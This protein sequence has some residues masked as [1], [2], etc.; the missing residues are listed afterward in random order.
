MYVF[1]RL[2]VCLIVMSSS[3]LLLNAMDATTMNLTFYAD[4]SQS[5]TTF[6]L[7]KAAGVGDV[8]RM[9]SLLQTEEY[10]VNCENEHKERPLHCAAAAGHQKAVEFLI[11]H[12]ASPLVQDDFKYTPVHKASENGRTGIVQHILSQYKFL[13]NISSTDGT[14]PLML[15]ARNGHSETVRVL[16]QF[17]AFVNAGNEWNNTALTMA[18]TKGD[19]TTV[20]ILLD[21]GASV[22]IK[23]RDGGQTPLEKAEMKVKA[24]AGHPLGPDFIQI[25]SMLQAAEAKR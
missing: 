22:F 24:Y 17:E 9:Q 1:Y 11:Q 16:C 23:S 20:E 15:A 10:S 12:G 18:V 21:A 14:M 6:E 5:Q 8:T 19:P 25:L 13:A 2:T 3:D 7:H 4:L